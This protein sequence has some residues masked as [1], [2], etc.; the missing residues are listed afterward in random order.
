VSNQQDSYGYYWFRHQSDGS[1]FIAC[2]DEEDGL[3]YMS[4]LGHPIPD[5]MNHATVLGRVPRCV[6]GGGSIDQ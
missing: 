5:I 2:R 4:G 1:T 3:W 6:E